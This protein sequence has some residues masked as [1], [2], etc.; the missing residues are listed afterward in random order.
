MT[1]AGRYA[2]QPPADDGERLT[3]RLARFAVALRAWPRR[4]LRLEEIWQLY[5]EADPISAGR[6]ERRAELAAALSTLERAGV[7]ARSKTADRTAQPPL[8]RRVTLS[9]APPQP[10]SVVL[11]RAT[12]WRPELAWASSAR[13]TTAQVQ[14]LTAVNA[15]LRDRG[16]DTDRAPLRERSLEVFG[17]EKTLDRLLGTGMFGPGRLTLELLRTFRAH[18]PLP[19]VHIGAG[20]VLLVAENADTFATLLECVRRDSRGVG[21]I[22]WGAGGAFEASVRSAGDLD[23]AV[24][25]IRY[26]GDLDYAGLRI[27]TNAC[28][29]ARTEGLPPLLPAVTLYRQL[30]ASRVRQ[31]GQPQVEDAACQAVTNWLASTGTADSSR[32][33]REVVQLLRDGQRVPQEAL[34][35]RELISNGKWAGCC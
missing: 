23:P 17:H 35:S 34:G 13:L 14:V 26:F 30:L 15:W 27:P 3:G 28:A 31:G 12:A 33:A 29:T 20:G 16:R 6:P 22:A 32:V 1:S 4:T 21:W 18:P 11:A 25:E 8:P 2:G 10:S 5:A 7:L 9:A 24:T 19:A